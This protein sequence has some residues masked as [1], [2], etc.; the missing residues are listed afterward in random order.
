M[1]ESSRG[2]NWSLGELGVRNTH[3]P[4]RSMAADI[5]KIVSAFSTS[6]I[7][8]SDFIFHILTSSS[9]SERFL[10][11]NLL[12]YADAIAEG[13]MKHPDRKQGNTR[14]ATE[15]VKSK[16]G[17]E[18][19]DLVQRNNGWHFS[20]STATA[21]QLQ[22]FRIEDMAEK[23][24]LIAPQLWD[25][26]GLLLSAVKPAIPSD[27]KADSTA[28]VSDEDDDEYMWQLGASDFGAVVELIEEEAKYSREE[29]LARR[30]K[31]ILTVVSHLN[32]Q[33]LEFD[34]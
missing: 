32:W 8:I 20:A 9:S 17:D 3:P 1:T 11:N 14:W 16:Y 4:P 29:R 18:I 6:N 28:C 15:F 25:L 33:S 26:V 22:E 30:R 31:A 10:Q 13:L 23:M 19:R 7:T 27:P 24:Q 12:A 34:S 2:W 5:K 21:T